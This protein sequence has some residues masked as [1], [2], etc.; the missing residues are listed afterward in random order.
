MSK[1]YR[2]TAAAIT[3]ALTTSAAQADG[4]DISAQRWLESWKAK[5]LV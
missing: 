2:V 1:L 4:T 5:T 3:A